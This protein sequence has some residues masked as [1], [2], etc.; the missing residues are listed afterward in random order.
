MATA[1]KS[2]ITANTPKSIS[3]GA[4]TIHKNLKYTTNTW[5]FDASIIGATSGGSKLT[6]TPEITDIEVD[7]AWVKVKGLT[8]KTGETATME[9]NFIELSSDIMKSA[10]LGADGTSADTT[11]NLI[12]SKAD[13]VTGDYFENI[14]FVGITLEGKKIIVV[15]DNA[16]CTSGMELEGKNKEAGVI[17]LT[18]ECHA[19]ID[20]D[21]DKLPW[22][23]YYPKPEV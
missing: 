11:Y 9:I 12:E 6:I 10:T 16:L 20:S 19:A 21:L 8:K 1:G 18:F 17:A 13:I 5:N 23:I 2:G 4:G 7:G 3:F 14:A 22:H 15:M